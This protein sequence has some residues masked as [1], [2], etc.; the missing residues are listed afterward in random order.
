MK[1]GWIWLTIV[2]L[3]VSA[4]MTWAQ[5]EPNA[6][7][8][9]AY[10]AYVEAYKAN[11][12]ATAEAKLLAAKAAQSDWAQPCLELG[13]LY[14]QQ[15]KYGPAAAELQ[16]A[17]QLDPSDANGFLYLGSAYAK[18]EVYSKAYPALKEAL[19]L[20]SS[21]TEATL[22]LASA[23]FNDG[24]YANAQV[25]YMAYVAKV[26]EDATAHMR[27]ADANKKLGKRSL[28]IKSYKNAIKADGLLFAAQYNLGNL[29]LESEDYADA[30]QAF[31]EAVKLEP[32]N[33]RA[34]FNL[35]IALHSQGELVGALA[36][37]EKVVS[38]GGSSKAARS[39]VSQAK[40][41]IPL[42]KEQIAADQ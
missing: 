30:Q 42:L 26:P 41:V 2:A 25:Q 6:E 22:L 28:A 38:V 18:Q 11:D 7:A 8:T 35:A 1:R 19:E 40:E 39:T 31:V 10:N 37:Y 3:T 27:L 17:T 21:L 23:Y 5:V 9:E 24:D 13:Q 34:H 15:E 33:F 14:I 20:D 32:K 36:Q 12:F 4:S 29:Y 16:T